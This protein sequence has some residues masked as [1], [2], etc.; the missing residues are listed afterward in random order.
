LDEQISG[1]GL[2]SLSPDGKRLAIAHGGIRG[3]ASIDV[4]TLNPFAKTATLDGV[5]LT[6]GPQIT[7]W[8]SDSK[9]LLTSRDI[10]TAD[11]TYVS[12]DVETGAETDLVKDGVFES[13]FSPDDREVAYTSGTELY[14]VTADASAPP[15]LV[16]TPA[17][18]PVAP[19]WSPDGRFIAFMRFFGGYDR[20]P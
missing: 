4:Y 16:F 13:A 15:R 19:V 10:C 11:E 7:A 8:S 3:P 2:T 18:A 6:G 12:V 20:C 1:A 5:V 17:H 9:H 14:V